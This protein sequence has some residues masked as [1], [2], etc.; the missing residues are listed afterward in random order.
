MSNEGSVLP[1]SDIDAIFKQATGMDIATP[2]AAK[3]A[4]LNNTP[5][6]SPA[7][8]NTK[9]PP[10]PA[11][12]TPPPA[13]AP[14]LSPSLSDDALKKIQATVAELS[15]R[16]ANVE[17]SISSLSSREQEVPDVK[18]PIQQL[19]LRLETTMKDLQKIRSQVGAISKGL[20]ATPDYGIRSDF[21]CESCHSQGF[22]ATPTRCTKCGREGWWGWWPKQT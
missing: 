8:T 7:V 10:E 1:Q 11:P 16:I 2:P 21:I 13:P 15:Q 5:P 6:S 18:T 3:P 9:P 12:T 19:S 17:T 22:V 20:E 4:A 14:P